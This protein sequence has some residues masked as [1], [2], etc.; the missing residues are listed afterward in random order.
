LVI[1]FY[2]EKSVGT[3]F[4]ALDIARAGMLVSQVQLDVAGHN[5]ANVNKE[6][7]SRQRVEV[8]TR[9]PN[10]RPYGAIGRGPAISDI[11][12]IRETFLDQIYREQ[13]PALGR[14]ETIANY[15]VRIQDIFQEP[16]DT[17]FSA[18]L[19]RF[20][21]ALQDFANNVEETPVRVSLL[22]EGEALAQSLNEVAR[23][24][25][26]LES[27]ANE[28]IRNTI[29]EINSLITRIVEMNKTIR[30]TEIAGKSANDLRDDRDLLVDQLSKIV[31]IT[32]R[33][34][35]DGQI[36]VLLGGVEIVGGTKY[37]TLST[38]VDTTIDPTRPDF[39][40]VVFSDNQEKAIISDGSLAGLLYMRDTELRSIKEQLN[41]IARVVAGSINSIHSQGRG[42]EL[43]SGAIRSTI[44]VPNASASLS[45][46]NLPY[47][48]NDGSFQLL[49]YDSSGNIATNLNVTISA[50]STSLTD[51]ANQINANPF[52]TASIDPDGYLTITPSSGY[53]FR[54]ANDTS[55]VLVAIGMNPFFTGYTA[56]TLSVNQDLI[57]NPRLISSGYSTNINETGDNTASLA[58]AKLRSQRI[59]SDSTQTADE[60]YQSMIVQIGINARANS[61]VLEMERSFI[62]DFNRRRQEVSGVNLDEEVTNLMLFQRAFEASTRIITVTDRMLDALLNII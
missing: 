28:E 22:Q 6:G 60:Y 52:F 54:F 33:E 58:M 7:Y 29:P 8:T 35:D 38:V 13:N 34:R 19:S 43:Y 30:D 36:D 56:S 15:F 1:R 10:Y 50:N 14:T 49:A 27:N 17:G 45:S 24:V 40:S 57:N 12:R 9:L 44:S 62:N 32:S 4:S 21:D 25:Y 26:L 18:H 23:Q 59:L 5:I 47:S 48:I 20:F 31:S 46:N 55:G 11:R 42:L 53:S 39:L 61:D 41:E 51:I 16:G 2:K 37:R 3:L